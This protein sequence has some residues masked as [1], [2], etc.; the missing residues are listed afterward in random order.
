MAPLMVMTIVDVASSFSTLM[1]CPTMKENF[2]K[3]GSLVCE[4]D[5]SSAISRVYVCSHFF[6]ERG[7]VDEQWLVVLNFMNCGS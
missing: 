3:R 5:V 2:R 7:E 4:L 1:W 6:G